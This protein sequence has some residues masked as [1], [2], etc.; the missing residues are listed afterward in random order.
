MIIPQIVCIDQSNIY[1]IL[2]KSGYKYFMHKPTRSC[3]LI[4]QSVI[5]T[6]HL[7]VMSCIILPVIYKRVTT[8]SKVNTYQ[9]TCYF[10]CNSAKSILTLRAKNAYN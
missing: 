6:P 3:Y 9:N 1:C 2:T 4:R 7:T 10:Y 8:T 5:D